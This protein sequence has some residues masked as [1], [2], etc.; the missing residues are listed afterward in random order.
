MSRGGLIVSGC[1]SFLIL[2]LVFFF[3]IRTRLKTKITG[4]GIEVAFPPIMNKWKKYSPEEIAKFEIRKYKAFLE[5]GGH[6]LKQRR[7]KGLSYTTS[8]DVG[9]Q[10]Y[11]KN[12][13]K[14][15]IGTQQK[16]GIEYAME[17]MM[18]RENSTKNG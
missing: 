16:Q 8:G 1:F 3:F 9:M 7:G 6:G 14:I 18:K 10:L 2:A 13:K 5:F 12:G 11:L 15:L 17:K 4:N